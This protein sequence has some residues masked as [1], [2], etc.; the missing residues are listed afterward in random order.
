MNEL[1]WSWIDWQLYIFTEMVSIFLRF[2][3]NDIYFLY[4]NDLD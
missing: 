3:W 2:W 4:V 1:S